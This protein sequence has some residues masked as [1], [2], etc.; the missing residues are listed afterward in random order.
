[1]TPRRLILASGSPRRHSL[2]AAAGFDFEIVVSGI[3][4]M[5]RE[6]EAADDFAMRM[7]REKAM[8]IAEQRPGAVVL[9]ADTIVVLGGRIFGKPAGPDEARAMLATLSARTHT[10]ITAYAIVRDGVMLE[11]R[12]VVSEVRFR[13]LTT[14]EIMRYV[15]SGEPLDKAGAYGIQDAGAAF[16]ERVIGSRDNVMG[17]PIREVAEALARHGIMP[18]AKRSN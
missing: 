18:S 7:S 13:A 8:S 12:P 1:M 11:N 16:I 10:V 6:G 3:D 9:A 4:E 5:R 2:L 15:S 17:L 14:S